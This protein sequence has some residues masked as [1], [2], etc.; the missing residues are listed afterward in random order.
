[1]K[2]RKAV[3]LVP[4]GKKGSFCVVPDYAEAACAPIEDSV[5][6]VAVVDGSMVGDPDLQGI[7]EEPFATVYKYVTTDEKGYPGE[8]I[9]IVEKVPIERGGNIII[10][11]K[12]E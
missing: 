10:R 3:A 1:M 6:G 2:G 9:E 8:K 4:F 12:K 7:V 11:L 5:E